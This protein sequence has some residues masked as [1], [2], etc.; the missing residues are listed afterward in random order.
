MLKLLLERGFHFNHGTD[1]QHDKESLHLAVLR[2]DS[3]MVKILLNHQ[4]KLDLELDGF[5]ALDWAVLMG[6]DDIVDIIKNEYRLRCII[7]IENSDRKCV[8]KALFNRDGFN[9]TSVIRKLAANG[10]DMNTRSVDGLSMLHEAVFDFDSDSLHALIELGADPDVMSSEHLIRTPLYDA[11][12]NGNIMAAKLLLDA[13]ASMEC[14]VKYEELEDQTVADEVQ[15]IVP[16][17]ELPLER[18]LLCAAVCRNLVEMVW[19]LLS[20]GYNVQQEEKSSLQWMLEKTKSKE[21]H[22]WLS[23]SVE[24]PRNLLMCCRDFIRK[25]WKNELKCY[26]EN[27]C[28]PNDLK[29][30]LLLKDVLGKDLRTIQKFCQW[31]NIF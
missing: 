7:P 26:I 15:F 5:T 18:S 28:I 17:N 3:E 29:D 9:R 24:S 21:I 2:N 8:I 20:C 23:D 27:Q 31:K 12:A 16:Y 19:L 11:V 22:L 14:K 25:Q 10:F 13:N 30:K 1:V 6:Y 4:I